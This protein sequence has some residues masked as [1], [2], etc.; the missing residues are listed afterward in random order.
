MGGNRKGKQGHAAASRTGGGHQLCGRPLLRAP[1]GPGRWED[2]ERG[3]RDSHDLLSPLPVG[4]GNI[5]AGHEATKGHKGGA[6]TLTLARANRL[7]TDASVATDPSLSTGPSGPIRG[8][9]WTS[10][11]TE[12]LISVRLRVSG[13]VDQSLP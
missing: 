3:S 12:L 7:K 6:V 8:H 13:E 5:H 11:Y 1:P 2:L 4:Q 10:V 9:L